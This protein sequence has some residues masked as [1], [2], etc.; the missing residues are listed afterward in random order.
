MSDSMDLQA[1]KVNFQVAQEQ[2]KRFNALYE[3]GLKSLTELETR[4]LKFQEV[5]AK[6]ISQE[7]KYLVTRN[8]LINSRIEL[9]RIE[10]VSYTHLD[11][12]KRQD[13]SMNLGDEVTMAMNSISEEFKEIILLLSLIHI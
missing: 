3:E 5:Q 12:Y 9:Q 1:E 11:V 4:K 7:N 2:L 10:A 8:E 6:L 13:L